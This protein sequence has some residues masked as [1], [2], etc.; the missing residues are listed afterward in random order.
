MSFLVI[1]YSP[2]LFSM[3]EVPFL[4]EAVLHVGNFS[5]VVS[6]VNFLVSVALP[7]RGYPDRDLV[8]IKS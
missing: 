1:P 2:E 3:V 4:N 5:G 8:K 7:A 6:F